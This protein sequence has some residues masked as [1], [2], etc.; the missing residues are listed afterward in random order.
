MP[1]QTDSATR[2]QLCKINDSL[3]GKKLR[4][5]GKVLSYDVVSGLIIL[6]DGAYGLLLD[7][8]MALDGQSRSWA[9]EH[10]STII[11]IGHLEQSAVGIRLYY[12]C[13]SSSTI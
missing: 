11:G 9:T 12:G 13:V 3:L 8:S 7:I 10:L 4:V 5:A 2:K 1:Q 6:V